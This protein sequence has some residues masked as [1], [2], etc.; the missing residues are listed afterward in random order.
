MAGASEFLRRV[1]H[2]WGL[3]VYDIGV[4]F[5]VGGELAKQVKQAATTPPVVLRQVCRSATCL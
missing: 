4:N 1:V 3:G 5:E 2:V